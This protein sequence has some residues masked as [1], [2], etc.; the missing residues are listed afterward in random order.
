[1]RCVCLKVVGHTIG[2]GRMSPDSVLC[3]LALFPKFSEI[4]CF[5]VKFS[6]CFVKF[7]N[8]PSLS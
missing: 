2:N 7:G 6:G 8:V 1:M 4:L 3:G 5:A